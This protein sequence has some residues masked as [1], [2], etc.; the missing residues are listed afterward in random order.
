MAK[1]P[2]RMSF[3]TCPMITSSWCRPGGTS[4]SCQTRK[5]K[6]ASSKVITT[7]HSQRG[8]VPLVACILLLTPRLVDHEWPFFAHFLQQRL[9]IEQIAKRL[10]A[11]RF[12]QIAMQNHVAYVPLSNQFAQL[13]VHFGLRR[14]SV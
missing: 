5:K 13:R 8:R 12:Q 11:A 7:G 10:D 6:A 14:E 4:F 2:R 9:T 3:A 1:C